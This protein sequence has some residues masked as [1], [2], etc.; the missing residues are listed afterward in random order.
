MTVET[1]VIAPRWDYCSTG[2]VTWIRIVTGD[3]SLEHGA[4]AGP[5]E[6]RAVG[7]GDTVHL[8]PHV[9]HRIRAMTD[10]VFVEASTAAAGW[11]GRRPPR[12]RLRA[13]GDDQGLRPLPGAG[14][15]QLPGDADL[16]CGAGVWVAG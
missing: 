13:F 6:T 9:R 12:R 10:L 5:L 2:L 16:V 11:R 14:D 3:A 1:A 4:S 15:A 8:P 7:P